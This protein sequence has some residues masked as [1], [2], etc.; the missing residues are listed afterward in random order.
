MINSNDITVISVFSGNDG[1]LTETMIKSILHFTNN[2][3]QFIIADNGK[4]KELEKKFDFIKMIE[5]KGKDARHANTSVRHASGLNIIFPMVKTKYTAIIESDT[6]VL[7]NDWFD[8]DT[9]TF[10]IMAS[11]KCVQPYGQ[12]LHMCFMVFKTDKLLGVDFMPEVIGKKDTGF[13]VY[14]MIADKNKIFYLKIKSC[15]SGDT[16]VFPKVFNYKQFEVYKD[17]DGPI[18]AHFGRGSDINRI[19]VNTLGHPENQRKEWI[20]I[21]NNYIKEK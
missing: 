20:K 14:N 18:A 3:P 5:N 6:L 15:K 4:N 7:R 2:H 10:D 1:G 11:L 17:D 13:R 9:D 12:Q 8:F 16:K 19:P 21:F